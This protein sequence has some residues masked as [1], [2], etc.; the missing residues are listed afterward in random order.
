MIAGAEA[1]LYKQTLTC[2]SVPVPVG[3]RRKECQSGTR[4]VQS[5]TRV[6]QEWYKSGTRVVQ[7]YS[8]TLQYIAVHCS[9]VQYSAVQCST[10][11]YIA[12]HCS[13]LQYIDTAVHSTAQTVNRLT[14]G[15]N[16]GDDVAIYVV[17]DGF[18]VGGASALVAPK[19]TDFDLGVGGRGVL[20]IGDQECQSKRNAVGVQGGRRVGVGA[21]NETG[22][23]VGE[24]FALQNQG[25]VGREGQAVGVGVGQGGTGWNRVEW[26]NISKQHQ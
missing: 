14:F 25:I 23:A 15:E 21:L 19:G 16:D 9:T 2:T 1:S 26:N 4:V 22:R 12:V 13:T 18:N 8:S 3:R 11:Q 5:G 6:V 20:Q 10:L 24:I 17:D 7:E